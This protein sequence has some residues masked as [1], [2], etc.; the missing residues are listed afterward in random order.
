MDSAVQRDHEPANQVAHGVARQPATARKTIGGCACRMPRVRM[1]VTAVHRWI[2][3]MIVVR[4]H[5]QRF[6]P[7]ARM[8][9]RHSPAD[10]EDRESQSQQRDQ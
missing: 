6:R 8:G 2:V 5:R 3:A 4:C 10:R 1:I 7:M 9:D